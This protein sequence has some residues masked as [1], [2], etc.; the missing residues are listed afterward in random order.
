VIG[1]GEIVEDMK[2]L[3]NKMKKNRL[4]KGLGGY[5]SL[6]G[7]I[8][9]VKNMLISNEFGREIEVKKKV[10]EVWNNWKRKK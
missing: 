9:E 4:K 10:K 1:Y 5:S 6:E 3:K 8:E 2:R 7:K